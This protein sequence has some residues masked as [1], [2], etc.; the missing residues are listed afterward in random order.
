M[1]P[2][3]EI[4]AFTARIQNTFGNTDKRLTDAA[5]RLL[6]DGYNETDIKLIIKAVY[7]TGYDEGYDDGYEAAVEVYGSESWS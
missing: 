5:L 4:R 2:D 7:H 1:L 3:W 6:H